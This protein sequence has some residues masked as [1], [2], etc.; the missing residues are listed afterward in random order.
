MKKHIL[1]LKGTSTVRGMAPISNSRIAATSSPRN[2]ELKKCPKCN[3]M[4]PQINKI[5][6]KCGEALTQ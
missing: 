6:F 1:D 4:N 2:N 3:E 5:C